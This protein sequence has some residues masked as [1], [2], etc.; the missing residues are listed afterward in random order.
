MTALIY[1]G[2][3]REERN[4]SGDKGLKLC[5]SLTLGE[6]TGGVDDDVFDKTKPLIQRNQMHKPDPEEKTS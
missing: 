4:C 2:M 6:L 5:V 3:G 1:E